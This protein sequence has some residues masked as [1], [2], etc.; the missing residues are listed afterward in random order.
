[1][2]ARLFGLFAVLFGAFYLSEGVPWLLRF[3]SG[4]TRHDLFWS[5]FQTAVVVFDFAIGGGSVLAGVGMLLRREWGRKAWL[6]LLALDLLLHLIMLP[7]NR[8]AGFDVSKSYGWTGLV[9]LLAV[10]SWVFLT[11]PRV[12]ARFR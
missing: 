2:W 10:V 8:A 3:A 7:A 6:A 11:R 1:M 12:K 4:A 9:V 5:H